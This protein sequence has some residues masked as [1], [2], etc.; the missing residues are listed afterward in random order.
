LIDQNL[1][2]K[3]NRKFAN[4][5]TA[6]AIALAPAL[7][8]AGEIAPIS[9]SFSIPKLLRSGVVAGKTNL[10]DGT[11]LIVGLVSY[12]A[13]DPAPDCVPPDD[14]FPA[15]V[16]NGV[17]VTP[18]INARPGDYLVNITMLSPA[19]QPQSVQT[20]VGIHGENL[21]GPSVGSTAPLFVV[22]AMIE[23]TILPPVRHD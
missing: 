21:R 10:P 20:I 1:G 4:L 15:T 11:K 3:M 8:R 22:H 13:C 19:Q 23:T 2:T 7:A 6:V 17:F 16:D 5:M 9:V 18:P 12:L 14:F